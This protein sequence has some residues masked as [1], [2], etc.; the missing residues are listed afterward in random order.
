MNCRAGY[1][2][3]VVYVGAV[4]E[5]VAVTDGLATL[6]THVFADVPES[7]IV[8]VSDASNQTWQPAMLVGEKSVFF[9]I[10]AC[11]MVLIN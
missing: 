9:L 7:P 1:V 2:L 5:Y 6:L 4:P 3:Y 10:N 11:D 8:V